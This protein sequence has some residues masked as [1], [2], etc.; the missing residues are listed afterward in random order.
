[1][2]KIIEK[3]HV[4]YDWPYANLS[5]LLFKNGNAQQAFDAASK[6]ANMNPSSA[7]N[8]YLGGK[9]LERLGKT[10]LALNW[11]QRSAAL[12]PNYA[13][14]QYLLAQIYHR[15]GKEEQAATARKRFERA[16]A[17]ETMAGNR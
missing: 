14:P 10:D 16:K 8:F 7:R 2:N 6:A 13:E 9:A 4:S 17:A 11:L 15:L 1:M 12:D 5:D 3:N